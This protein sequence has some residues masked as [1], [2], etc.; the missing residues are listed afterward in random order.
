MG[1]QGKNVKA[2][3]WAWIKTSHRTLLYDNHI[4]RVATH[5][6]HTKFQIPLKHRKRSFLPRVKSQGHVCNEKEG[7]REKRQSWNG[8]G[9]ESL[10]KP[11]SSNQQLRDTDPFYEAGGSCLHGFC[12]GSSKTGKGVLQ[13]LPSAVLSLFSPS[14]LPAP[15]SKS[16]C[17]HSPVENLSF[18]LVFHWG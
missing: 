15:C 16:P 18:M 1:K 11:G 6:L 3:F 7:E 2:P 17:F 8:E 5:V 4:G 10:R 14:P 13:P 12:S 9:R